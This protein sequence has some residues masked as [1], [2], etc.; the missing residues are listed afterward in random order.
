MTECMLGFIKI[1]RHASHTAYTKIQHTQT[2]NILL[3]SQGR[4][5]SSDAQ[6]NTNDIGDL[7]VPYAKKKR[8]PHTH[9][10]YSVF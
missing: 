5:H 7:L 2:H 9:H 1:L 4:C 3:Q 8:Q 10:N 6:L